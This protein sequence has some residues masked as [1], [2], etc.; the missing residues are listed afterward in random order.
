MPMALMNNG[1]LEW[2]SRKWTAPIGARGDYV[3][4]A[5]ITAVGW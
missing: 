1:K 3:A 5:M 2:D 4:A